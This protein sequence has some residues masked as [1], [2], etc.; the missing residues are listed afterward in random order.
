[1]II[2]KIISIKY[3][4]QR[5]NIYCCFMEF[6]SKYLDLHSGLQKT[7]KIDSEQLKGLF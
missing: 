3:I 6:S 5:S 2:R 7:S 1:M 4:F